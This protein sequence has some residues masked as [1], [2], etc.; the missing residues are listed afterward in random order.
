M[1]EAQ[2]S[3]LRSF[4]QVTWQGKKLFGRCSRLG[5][6]L[7]PPKY[8]SPGIKKKVFHLL[9]PEI[10]NKYPRRPWGL[11]WPDL[12]NLLCQGKGLSAPSSSLQQVLGSCS[13]TTIAPVSWADAEHGK[14]GPW[15]LQRWRRWLER[16][17]TASQA[18]TR[19]Q[20][21]LK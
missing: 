2:Y 18:R 15:Q 4:L 20:L 11:Y 6:H 1:D 13:G 21:M 19:K 14:T 7:C 8:F 3:L 5:R 16:N 12:L 10:F 9:K 17:P